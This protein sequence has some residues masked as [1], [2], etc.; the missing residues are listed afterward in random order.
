MPRTSSAPQA[1]S[2]A[3]Q[4]GLV[5]ASHGRHVLVESADGSR[6]ICHPRGKKS[7]ALAGDLIQWQAPPTGQG[8]EGTIE[9]VLPRRNVFYRQDEVRIKAFAAN[10]DQILIWLA[11]EPDF[12][13]QLLGRALIAAEAAQIPALIVLNKADLAAAHAHAWQRLAP[14]RAMGYR[15]LGVSLQQPCDALLALKQELQ[16]KKT[17]LMGPSGTGKSSFI[18]WL[19]PTANVQTNEIS[20]ALNSGRHTT[21]STLLHW[22]DRASGTAAI[23]SPG[24]QEFGIAHLS[25]DDLTRCMPD[26]A[27]HTGGCRFYNCTHLHEPGCQ[28]L[29]AVGQPLQEDGIDPQRHQLYAQLHAQLSASKY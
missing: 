10:I 4:Q 28:V 26:I 9:A 20:R 14:Y 8:E 6:R 2:P 29:S 15:T 16:G 11:A 18:N 25:A 13:P 12:S 22:V 24:F 23:D 19:L 5:V 7:Q 21:T 1:A 17:L 3:L 27:R